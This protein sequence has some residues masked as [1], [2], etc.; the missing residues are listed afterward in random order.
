M[1]TLC[2]NIKSAGFNQKVWQALKKIPRGRVTTYQELAKHLGRPKAA[3]AVGNAL[4]K[5]PQAP[6]APCHRV[7][8]SDGGLGG[9]A[10]GAKKK[11]ELLELEGVE[12]VKGRIEEFEEK[13]FRFK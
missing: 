6:Q 9:Y 11:N 7:V 10:R 3:R 12:V 5:N 13:I 4:N 8:K 1:S 2:K